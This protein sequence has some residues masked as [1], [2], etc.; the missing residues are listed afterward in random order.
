M[1]TSERLRFCKVC[2]SRKIDLQTGIYCGLSG[3][4]P[5]FEGKCE[6]FCV[7]KDELRKEKARQLAIKQQEQKESSYFAPEQKGMKK[8]VLGGL[9]MILIAIVWFFAGLA[10]DR[11]F[12]YP[13]VLLIIGI[14]AIVRGA[15]E[16]NLIGEKYRSTSN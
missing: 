2:S 5:D 14:V 3:Q 13:S 16:G 6:S 10:V 11:I 7:D 1:T 8:G 15:V 9:V 12:Y 4:K